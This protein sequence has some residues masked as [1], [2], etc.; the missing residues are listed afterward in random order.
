MTVFGRVCENPECEGYGQELTEVWGIRSG[1]DEQTL[2]TTFCDSCSVVPN[3]DRLTMDFKDR[4]EAIREAAERARLI[5][6]LLPERLD[7]CH[8]PA[9]ATDLLQRELYEAEAVLYYALNGEEMRSQEDEGV[10]VAF[11]KVS[12]RSEGVSE[13]IGTALE[14]SIQDPFTD[15]ITVDVLLDLPNQNDSGT[16]EP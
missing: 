3:V 6:H 4:Y 11:P 2:L 16:V 10:S 13:R 1:S 7:G 12:E 15:E 9:E 14:H 5:L 8:G